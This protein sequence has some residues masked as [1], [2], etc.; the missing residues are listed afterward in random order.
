MGYYTDEVVVVRPY[1]YNTITYPVP[2]DQNYWISNEEWELN[3][4]NNIHHY[5]E[6]IT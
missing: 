3:K 1:D 4:L 6:D 2:F 5:K